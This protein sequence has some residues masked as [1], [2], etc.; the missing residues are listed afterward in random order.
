[1]LHG[2]GPASPI[3]G[4]TSPTYGDKIP[5]LAFIVEV[6]QTLPIDLKTEWTFPV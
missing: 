5:A 2:S 1:V 4:W 3:T 6:T